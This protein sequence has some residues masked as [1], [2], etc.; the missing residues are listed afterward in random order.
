MSPNRDGCLV[1]RDIVAEFYLQKSANV[2]ASDVAGWRIRQ[3]NA[4]V[5][6][7]S[8]SLQLRVRGSWVLL[9]HVEGIVL[10]VGNGGWVFTTSIGN[11]D[12]KFCNEIISYTYLYD[13]K[14]NKKL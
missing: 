10:Q 6:T 12:D 3:K 4:S 1:M 11:V 8:S 14:F 5:T 9:D 7:S 13:F 2:W